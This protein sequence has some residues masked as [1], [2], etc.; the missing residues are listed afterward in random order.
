MKVERS[1]RNKEIIS[2]LVKTWLKLKTDD[3]LILIR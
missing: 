2:D 3:S 1:K